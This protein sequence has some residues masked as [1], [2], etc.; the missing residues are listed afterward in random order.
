MNICFLTSTIFDLGGVQRVVSVIASEL[1]NEHNITILCTNGDYMINRE[2]YNLNKEVKVIVKDDI[3]KKKL[4]TKIYSR[5]LRMLNSKIGFL[6]NE[7]CAGFLIGAYYPIEIQNRFINYC[8]A[9]DYDVIVGIGGD[10]SLLLSIIGDKLKAKTIAWQHN[11]Y[12]AYFNTPHRYNWKQDKFFK[13]FV[14]NLDKYIV[15]TNEDKY[16]ID[17]NF[18]IDSERIYNPCSFTS[19]K[20]SNCKEKN[21]VF[22][23]RLAEEQKG[24]DLLIKAFYKVSLIHN[25]WKLYIVGDGEDRDNIY[26]LICNLKLNSKIRLKPSTSKIEEYYLNSSILVS[27][28][29]WEGFGL[30]ITEAMECG[31]PVIAFANSGPKEIINKPNENGILVQCGNINELAES[32]IDLIE[33]EE[34]RERIG[35]ESVIRAKDFSIR[36]IYEEW[37][38]ILQNL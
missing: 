17:K 10:Y 2:L 3:F 1:V 16:L 15:L 33:N 26:D 36:K 7:K 34:K 31:L 25:D 5:L 22:V 27:S 35:K 4:W 20:K 24:L 23:G 6:D 30:V 13:K 8:N 19:Y 28:S 11:S 12:D 18:N 38:R 21:I 14:K 29:R 9:K 32:I 37:N